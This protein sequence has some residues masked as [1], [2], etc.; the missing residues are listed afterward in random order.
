MC[1]IALY[2]SLLGYVLWRFHLFNIRERDEYYLSTYYEDFDKL[3]A[4]FLNDTS[5]DF[6]VFI[7]DVNYDNDDN[8]YGK[9]IYHNFIN[10]DGPDDVTADPSETSLKFRDEIIP[11][12]LCP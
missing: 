10:M 3:G 4:H 6:Q 5:V 2:L 1:T 11:I 9:I 7:N 8:P 12:A